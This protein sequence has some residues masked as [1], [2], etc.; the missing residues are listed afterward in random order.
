MDVGEVVMIHVH[1]DGA[2]SWCYKKQDWFLNKIKVTSSTEKD[3]FDFLFYG[4]VFSVVAVI[5]RGGNNENN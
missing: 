3:P 1:K 2:S 5:H 4:W